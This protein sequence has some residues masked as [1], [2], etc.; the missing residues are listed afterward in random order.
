MVETTFTIA[1]LPGDGIGPEVIREAVKVLRAVES[2]LP[3][4]RFSLTE[5]PCGA[6]AWV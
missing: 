1:V 5:Y 2:H 3:D 4:V 6:A